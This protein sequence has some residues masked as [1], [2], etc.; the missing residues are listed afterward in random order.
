M[1]DNPTP[2]ADNGAAPPKKRTGF[3]IFL[4]VLL[5]GVIGLCLWGL[6]VMKKAESNPAI[7][8]TVAA[9][10]YLIAPMKDMTLSQ[11]EAQAEAISAASLA[12]SPDPVKGRYVMVDG[13]I[14]GEESTMVDQ[15]MSI[16]NMVVEN[17]K[18]ESKG[19]VLNDGVV[20]VDISGD[21]SQRPADGDWVRG[22]GAVLVVR[23][24]DVFGLPI[25]GPDLKKEFGNGIDE[26][27]TVVFV[28]AKG[29]KKITEAEA[30]RDSGMTPQF[31]QGQQPSASG[32]G[33]A[34]PPAGTAPPAEGTAPPAEGSTPPAGGGETP[35]ATPPAAPPADGGH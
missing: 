18:S 2:A 30:T 5:I 20:L 9:Y 34:A 17:L 35:P 16:P 27:S 22:Y 28:I 13:Q 33:A 29:I 8:E 15:N 4:Y 24:K 19:Y 11:I 6:S 14:Q 31:P 32:D 1:S 3:T 23:V 26:T 25:V 10:E 12:A 21:T 7:R